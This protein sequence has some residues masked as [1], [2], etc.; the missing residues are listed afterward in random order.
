VRSMMNKLA[1]RKDIGLALGDHAVGAAEWA[2]TPL[3]RVEVFRES[4]PIGDDG[5]APAVGRLL[6]RRFTKE[7]LA[8]ARVTIGLPALRVF[9]STRP[10]QADNREASPEI[11]LHEVLQSPNLSV[12]DMIVDMIR[13]RP[14]QRPLASI[15]ACRKKYM[16][17]VLSA[18]AAAGVEPC[19]AE[20]SPCAL[21]R[22]AARRLRPPG[23]SRAFARVILGDGRGLAVLMT[24]PEAPLMWRPFDLAPGREAAAIRAAVASLGSLGRFCGQEGELDTVLVH[25]RPDLGPLAEVV[26]AEALPGV[27]LLRHDAPPLDEAA[28]A[29]GLAEG[30]GPGASAFNLV[31]SLGR[32]L[33]FWEVFPWGQAVLQVAALVAASLFLRHHLI[34]ARAEARGALNED[35]R[36]AWAAR[37]PTDKLRAEK[38]D[39]EQRLDSVRT[40]L[41]SRVSWTAH[42]RDMA[43][44][45]GPAIILTSFQGTAELE[46]GRGKPR[47]SLALKLAAPIKKAGGMPR[48]IDAFLRALRDAP[49][50]KRDF[51]EIELANLQWTAAI[52][53]SPSATPTA[54]FGVTCSPGSKS[55]PAPAKPPADAKKKA[56][57][58]GH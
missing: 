46:G 42:A 55:A 3:G 25:G 24:A 56:E 52:S 48:E 9:F 36:Y 37:V 19:V 28:I 43:A 27:K 41:A 14:G 15:V 53:T 11:L 2:T 31:R 18:L 4:E 12:D 23:R 26:E 51:P 5:L 39:L 44:R 30:P 7:E 34:E 33:S 16:A 8:K 58:G 35:A 47:R 32:G 6:K 57:A 50:L 40:F 17:G 22:D 10:I 13:L 21:L 45:L 29:A 54:T 38:K 49:L 20:P 1:L